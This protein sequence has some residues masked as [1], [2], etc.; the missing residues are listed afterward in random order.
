MY[1]IKS[2]SHSLEYLQLWGNGLDHLKKGDI[3]LFLENSTLL[4]KKIFEQEFDENISSRCH[5]RYPDSNDLKEYYTDIYSKKRIT[6]DTRIRKNHL[7]AHQYS[8][9]LVCVNCVLKNVNTAYD[10]IQQ[11]GTT[12]ENSVNL[13]KAFEAAQATSFYLP[14]HQQHTA[15]ILEHVSEKEITKINNDVNKFI[16]QHI[17]V[18]PVVLSSYD[19]NKILEELTPLMDKLRDKYSNCWLK[20]FNQSTR[21]KYSI[22]GK[23]FTDITQNQN[24]TAAKIDHLL[25]V[26]EKNLRTEERNSRYALLALILLPIMAL[27]LLFCRKPIQTVASL[28]RCRKN[29]DAIRRQESH[30]AI[31][32]IL[33]ENDK[34]VF[35]A[36]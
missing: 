11:T 7:T 18:P 10:K 8:I 20:F 4:R 15:E 32:D 21:R 17:E 31:A 30:Y 28:Q 14:P 22:L 34:Q 16:E 33:D 29:L 27:P 2:N 26:T 9:Y 3:N 5:Y 35:S 1:Q 19:V 25:K 12:E 13:I 24:P 23:C 36:C 6:I